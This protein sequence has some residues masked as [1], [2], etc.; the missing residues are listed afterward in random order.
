MEEEAAAIEDTLH[1]SFSILLGEWGWLF[2]VAFLL[3]IFRQTIESLV[4]SLMM[5]MGSDFATDD[6]ILLNGKPARIVRKGLWNTTFFVYHFRK[7]Q[8]TGGSKKV[9][10]N[11]QLKNLDI[12]KPLPNIHLEDFGIFDD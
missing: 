10:S 8:I 11:D 1:G 9:V 2:L 4:A 12:E 3:L 5:F 7:G 6:I